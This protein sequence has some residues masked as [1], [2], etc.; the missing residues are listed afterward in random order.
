MADPGNLPPFI[1]N[2]L[3]GTPDTV[4]ERVQRYL[5]LGIT[6]VCINTA[7]PGRAEASRRASLRRFAEEAAPGF[8]DQKSEV[9]SQGS[10]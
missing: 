9:R 3:V 7:Q 6:H 4:A 1:A 8:R 2:Q 10:E 5:D